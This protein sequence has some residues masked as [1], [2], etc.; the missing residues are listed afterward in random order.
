MLQLEDSKHKMGEE[1]NKAESRLESAAAGLGGGKPGD[2][3]AQGEFRV[4]TRVGG[5]DGKK[6]KDAA[7]K[8]PEL[9]RGDDAQQYYA[10]ARTLAKAPPQLYRRLDETKEWAE[11]NYYHL[12]IQ[13]QVAELV[14]ASAFWLD[15][16]KAE[17][18]TPFLSTHLA[19]AS[20]NFTEMMLALAVLDLPFAAA[21]HEAKFDGNKMKIGRAHV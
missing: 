17:G 6:D 7:K 5:F 12:P 20:H 14:P 1:V 19:D 18:K 21:K 9:R 15:Y 10:N 2:S 16:A 3:P 13:Q 11:N 4:H 8:M